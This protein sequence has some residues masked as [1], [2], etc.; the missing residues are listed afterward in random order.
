MESPKVCISKPNQGLTMIEV[1]LAMGLL[2]II[3][4]LGLF[5]S[6][7]IL[8][9]GSFHS[10][11]DMVVGVLRRA[12][13]LA[14]NNVCSGAGCADGKSHGVHFDPAKREIVIFQGGGY[15]ASDPANETIL[16]DNKTVYIDASSS[17]DIIFD[18]ISGNSTA[19]TIILK[20]GAGHISA[21]ETNSEG[22]IDWR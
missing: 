16:F 21:V 19:T 4:S 11:R 20:D 1:C 3:G 2:A 7:E 15:S 18:R 14:V 8:R 12:R 13:S 9:G 6:S 5:M 17:V 10:D 22:R